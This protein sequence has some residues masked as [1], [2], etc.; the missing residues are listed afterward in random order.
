MISVLTLIVCALK[1]NQ[2]IMLYV[3]TNPGVEKGKKLY[4]TGS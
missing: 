3:W 2:I 1:S 4:K